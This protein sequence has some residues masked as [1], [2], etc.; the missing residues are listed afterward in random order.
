MI[1]KLL[2]PVLLTLLLIE[3]ILWIGFRQGTAPVIDVEM[4]QEIPGLSSEVHFQK[5]HL[6][7][8]THSIH[9][10]KKEEGTLRIII[11]GA[12]TAEQATQSNEDTWGLLLEKNL[13]EA[14]P[15]KK[16]EVGSYAT[17]GMKTHELFRWAN[18]EL[19]SLEPDLV[20]TLLGIN[21]LSTDL[22]FKNQGQED[23]LMS[24]IEKKP[25][26]LS[27]VASFSQIARYLNNIQKN[28]QRFKYIRANN[29]ANFDVAGLQYFRANYHKTPFSPVPETFPIELF[30][31]QT[32]WLFQFLNKHDIP[33]LTLTQPSLFKEKLDYEIEGDQLRFKDKTITQSEG[34]QL[35]KEVQSL[36]FILNDGEE[37]LR[38]QPSE[39]R[40]GLDAFNTAQT[41]LATQYSRASFP[42]H[43]Q[44][45]PTGENFFDDCHFTDLGSKRVAELITPA[46]I[47]LI[48]ED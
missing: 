18:R 28:S 41:K 4:T 15:D 21:N 25:G 40:R 26:I 42:L 29:G 17:G 9:Q 23:L 37:Y 24:Y 6:G 12:S 16:I 31:R 5:N 1:K 39:M 7:L 13:Q 35:V 20:I 47:D 48:K 8:R 45:E 44:L 19:T 34:A 32:S 10:R 22:M 43:E 2:F 33:S 36:W 11:L 27:R 14:L 46:V 38:L 30:Q 3:G